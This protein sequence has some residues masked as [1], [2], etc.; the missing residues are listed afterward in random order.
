MDGAVRLSTLQLGGVRFANHKGAVLFYVQ[1]KTRPHV[2][3]PSSLTQGVL[4]LLTKD[5]FTHSPADRYC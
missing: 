3:A 1:W 2:V 5:V 4:D